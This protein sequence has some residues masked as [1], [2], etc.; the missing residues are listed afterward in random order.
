MGTESRGGRELAQMRFWRR[1][2]EGR[3]V[4]SIFVELTSEFNRVPVY[5]AMKSALTGTHR[6]GGERD[7]PLPGPAKKFDAVFGDKYVFDLIEEH[8]APT[9]RR[10]LDRVRSGYRH[11]APKWSDEL[12]HFPIEKASPPSQPLRLLNLL[13]TL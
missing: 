1:V 12:Q 10:T 6:T 2:T 9:E 4:R 7:L 5:R 8:L 11:F 13:I 3:N